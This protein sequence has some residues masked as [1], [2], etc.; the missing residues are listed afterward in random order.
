MEHAAN[1]A[2][3]EKKGQKGAGPGETESRAGE[4]SKGGNSMEE[5]LQRQGEEAERISREIEREARRFPR[6]LDLEEEGA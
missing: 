4:Q 2:N 1:V 6:S 3:A 5:A